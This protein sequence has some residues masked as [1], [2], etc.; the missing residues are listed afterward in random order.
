LHNGS[1]LS[2][3]TASGNLLQL[4][5]HVSC[6][7]QFVGHWKKINFKMMQLGTSSPSLWIT[8]MW[9]HVISTNID[10]N[11]LCRVWL[12]VQSAEH[13]ALNVLV[14]F[15]W[16]L[17]MVTCRLTAS[18][19]MFERER[20]WQLMIT[21]LHDF[22]SLLHVIK[23]C[24]LCP[25]FYFASSFRSKMHSIKILILNVCWWTFNVSS[26]IEET[27]CENS[28]AE[29]LQSDVWTTLIIPQVTYNS[30]GWWFY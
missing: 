29:N 6:A 1:A 30:Q 7:H 3:W 12:N 26:R 4:A 2:E 17:A 20:R 8:I 5:H 10:P 23:E 21:N 16:C 25:L 19:F 24:F 15:Y 13:R 18:N 11:S 22:I 27:S 9:L 28:C 14:F